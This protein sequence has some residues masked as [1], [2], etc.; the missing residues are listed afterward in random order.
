MPLASVSMTKGWVKS[1]NTKTGTVMS[2]CLRSSKADSE[3]RDHLKL[4]RSQRPLERMFEKLCVLSGDSSH[5]NAP[6]L[7]LMCSM[8]C[9]KF[10]LLLK[11]I[12][13]CGRIG[14]LFDACGKKFQNV[15]MAKRKSFASVSMQDDK[16][17]DFLRTLF[18][19]VIAGGT[20]G[21]VVETALYPIDTIKTRL[22]AG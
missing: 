3:A 7:S 14:F 16:P 18:E 17:C 4:F 9:R 10:K 1:G 20:A 8:P 12:M 6:L 22:Q 2:A 5:R 15:T 13:H 21:V 19:G 11:P